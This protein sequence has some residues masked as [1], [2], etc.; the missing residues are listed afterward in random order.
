MLVKAVQKRDSVFLCVCLILAVAFLMPWETRTYAQIVGATLSGTVTDATGA[1]LPNVHVSIKNTATG[2]TRGIAADAAGFYTATNLLPGNY[3]VTYSASGFATQVSSGVNLTVGAQQVLNVSLRVGQ[4]SQQVTVT[5]EAPTVELAS[6]ALNA[7]VEAPTIVGLPLNGRSWTDLASL[8][9]GVAGVETQVP[10]GD[11]GRGNRGFGAQIIISG[12]RPTQNNYRLDGISLNDYSNGGPGSVL[13]GNLG[14]DAV[15]EFSVLTSTF[16]AEY[17]KTSGGVVNAISR[18]GTNQIHGN[19]YE[20]L[21]NSALDARNFFDPPTIPAFHRNQFGASIGGPIRKDKTFYFGD[22]EGIR[23]SKGVGKLDT[24]PSLAARGIGPSGQPTVALV[25]FLAPN[26]PPPCTPNTPLPAQGQPGAAPNPDPTTHIDAAVLPYLLGMYPLPN[27]PAISGTDTANF[28][29]VGHR[30]VREDFFTTRIDHH[31]SEKDSIFGTYMFD[32]TPFTS[33]E[34]LGVVLLGALTKRQI[35]AI[36]ETH[37]FTQN[38]V[39]TVRLGYNRDTVDNNQPVKAILPAA[40]DHSLAAI[41]GRYANACLCPNVGT[42]MEGGLGGTPTYLYRWNSYQVYDDAFL[43]KGRHSLKFGFGYERDQDNQLVTGDRNGQFSFGSM[44]AL[45]TNRPNKIRITPPGLLTERSLRQSIVGAYLQ[46]DWRV[47]PSLMLNLGLR[48]E[49]STVPFDTQGQTASLYNLTDAQPHCGRLVTGCAATG[50]FFNNPTLH[51]FAP[52]VGF[53]WDPFPNGSAKGKTAVRGGFGIFDSLPLTYEYLTLIGQVAPFYQLIAANNLPVG[54]FPSGAFTFVTTPGNG[55]STPQYASVENHPHRNYVMQWSLNIQ[56]ELTHDLTA[57]I[58]YVGT[59][60]VHQPF[61]VDDGDVVMPTLTS[62]GYLWPKVDVL[63]NLYDPINC[64]E[65]DPNANPNSVCNPPSKLNDNAGD[66]RYLNWAA[67][68]SYHALQVGVVKRLNHGFQI[69]GSFTWQKSIDNNS[70]V[71]AGD[72]FSNSISSMD[73]FDLHLSRGLSDYNV[74]RTLVINATWLVPSIKS[75]SGPLAWGLNGWQLSA[76][77]K[78]N[79]GVPFSALFGAQGP[80][81]RGTLS[82]DDYAYPSGVAG[83]NPI[84]LNFRNDPGGPLYVNPKTSCFTVPQAPNQ[85]FWNANCDPAPPSVGAPLATGDLSCYNLRGNVGRNT[86]IGP[87][88]TNLDFSVF[89]NNYIKRISESFNVQFR[90][91]LF[92]IMNHANFNVPSLG[93]GNTNMLNGDGTVNGS[94]GLL[95]QTTTDPREIQFAIKVIW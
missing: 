64:H 45:L 18:A 89:K 53:A 41:P 44:Q 10:F 34:P 8:Q 6:S 43:T 51:D 61:R 9:P 5:G 13:G 52:R 63:G 73:W 50:P 12:A 70:G 49:M 17:G 59:H 60:G 42:F 90:A 75:L 85:A 24:V 38:L 15:E 31:F 92:N 48:Y 95:T 7:V 11:S 27:G 68:S 62:A 39:N 81:P 65:T 54:S 14:V 87:G 3:E 25:C 86:L 71:I 91:E 80:D 20:F 32:R 93:D 40:A 47:R 67:S 66:I 74:G 83:C 57:T 33:D 72:Q 29:F 23:Q 22:Y 16:S 79:D 4:I 35:V 26:A 28:N 46:D 88:L 69:Q 56:R 94:A 82:S 55:K 36:E 2:I 78:A 1:A 37:S 58:G 19:A 84:D 21:R 30:I 77:F 76:V